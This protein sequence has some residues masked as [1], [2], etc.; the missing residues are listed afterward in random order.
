MSLALTGC[1]SS[2]GNSQ[3]VVS[4]AMAVIGSGAVSIGL[5]SFL[6]SQAALEQFNRLYNQTADRILDSYEDEMEHNAHRILG[7]FG[8]SE[9]LSRLVINDLLDAEGAALSTAE[10]SST[11]G[12]VRPNGEGPMRT[13]GLTAFL[14]KFG[15]GIQAESAGVWFSSLA[16]ALGH[17]LE[18]FIPVSLYILT[19]GIDGGIRWFMALTSLLLFVCHWRRQQLLGRLDQRP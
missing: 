2:L 19:G 13:V 9:I 3:L 15:Q 16:T 5:G 18:G 14:L 8:V 7:P 11:S 1:A 4:V 17:L 10:H 12:Q 6:A